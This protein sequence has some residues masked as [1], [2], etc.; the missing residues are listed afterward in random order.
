M[1]KPTADSA[2]SGGYGLLSGLDFLPGLLLWKG[3][4]LREITEDEGMRSKKRFPNYDTLVFSFSSW[5]LERSERDA[6]EQ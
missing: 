4:F 5:T 2:S 3:P 6:R 1:G